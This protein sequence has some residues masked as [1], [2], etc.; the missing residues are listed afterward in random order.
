[1]SPPA[2]RGQGR[3]WPEK[4]SPSGAFRGA[5]VKGSGPKSSPEAQPALGGCCRAGQAPSAA[6][7]EEDRQQQHG[8][9]CAPQAPC[10]SPSLGRWWPCGLTCSCHTAGL[11][12][13]G[14]QSPAQPS[15][16]LVRAATQSQSWGS[17]GSGS[18]RFHQPTSSSFPVP[19]LRWD[20]GLRVYPSERKRRNNCSF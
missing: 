12:R 19:V 11:C 15:A 13:S 1:M 4:E 14:R 16:P 18:Q 7:P 8:G 3:S 20:S 9:L 2:P 6:A 5:D 10:Q 17:Q